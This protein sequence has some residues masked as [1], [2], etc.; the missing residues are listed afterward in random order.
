MSSMTTSP[1]PGA[2]PTPVVLPISRA[3]IWL[4]VTAIV[5]LAAYYF[6]GVD[7]GMT[8]VFGH[9]MFVHEFVHDARH[10]LGFPC[11]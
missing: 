6:I 9:Q 5:A 10:F 8:S 1:G 4:T 7:G 3:A 2:V 11:H